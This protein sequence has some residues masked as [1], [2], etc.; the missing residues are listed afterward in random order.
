VTLFGYTIAV[1]A[2][3]AMMAAMMLPALWPWLVTFR[4][5]APS[6]Y[7]ERSPAAVVTLFCGGYL[8]VWL[9]YS[10]AAAAVQGGLQRL[11]LLR[12]DMVLGATAGGLVL[13]V[14]G[15]FQLTPLKD[16]CLSHCR[17]PMSFFLMRWNDGASAPFRMGARHGAFCVGCCWALMAMAFALGL[18]SLAWMALLTLMIVAEQRAPRAWRLRQVF[19]VGLATWGAALLAGLP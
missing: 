8:A 13:L 6:A 10:A 17:N 5:M 9:C 15:I 3:F 16:A 1:A 18:M 19:G 14:A 7:P 4:R 11:A 12:A 2:W